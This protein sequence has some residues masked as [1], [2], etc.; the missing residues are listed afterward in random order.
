[1]SHS[2]LSLHRRPAPAV[3]CHT[4]IRAPLIPPSLAPPTLQLRHELHDHV[5]AHCYTHAQPLHY[6]GISYAHVQI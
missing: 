2:S 3:D 4:S 1:M 5:R 6:S